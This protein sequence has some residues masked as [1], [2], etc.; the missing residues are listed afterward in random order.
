M[1]AVSLRV[2]LLF[3]ALSICAGLANAATVTSIQVMT[4]RSAK[5]MT[6]NYFASSGN[7][8]GDD[9]AWNTT[10][11]YSAWS[12]AVTAPNGK[13]LLNSS[14]K[15]SLP[16]SGSYW[17]YMGDNGTDSSPYLEV[18]LKFSDGTSTTEVFKPSK[19]TVQNDSGGAFTMESHSGKGLSFSVGFVK[20]P[21]PAYQYAGTY[22]TYSAG[23]SS[24]TNDW[25][26]SI[27]FPK[28]Q[29]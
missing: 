27:Q 3:V 4:G 5:G 20:S 11:L 9:G 25:V 21:S 23:N 12:V 15:T 24:G 22:K 16:A 1:R 28:Q 6:P 7:P 8:G 10:G 19:G 14:A 2:I 17:F 26:I 29:P 18:I 13:K